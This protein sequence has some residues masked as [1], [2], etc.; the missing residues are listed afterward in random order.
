MQDP[1]ALS[2][3]LLR[4]CKLQI[5]DADATQFGME[6]IDGPGYA[7]AESAGQRSRQNAHKL[8]EQPGQR[9]FESVAQGAETK[10]C[11]G[12]SRIYTDKANA[13]KTA[14]DHADF[15]DKPG[16]TFLSRFI[17]V[18]LRKSAALLKLCFANNQEP[19]AAFTYS[20]SWPTCSDWSE[21]A[22]PQP[23]SW[24]YREWC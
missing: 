1:L 3:G 8:D 4:E 23:A 13:Q 10:P 11:H 24:R 9:V 7:Y 14:A 21:M 18:H 6:K 12:F 19:T 20:R 22:R 17:R 2:A 15:A 16:S 5:S